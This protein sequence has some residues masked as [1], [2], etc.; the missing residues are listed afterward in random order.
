M[1]LIGPVVTAAFGALFTALALLILRRAQTARTRERTWRRREAEV[2]GFDTSS[3]G[4]LTVRYRYLDSAENPHEAS[5]ELSARA[6]RFGSDEQNRRIAIVVNPADES[7]SQLVSGG[8]GSMVPL[9]VMCGLF[10]LIGFAV[11]VGALVA[12]MGRL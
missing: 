8:G 1:Q 7:Q 2:L 9:Y 10:A 6:V 5:D 3:G 12:L 4:R 11:C